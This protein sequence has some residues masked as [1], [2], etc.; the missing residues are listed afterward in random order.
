MTKRAKV[1]VTITGASV[2]CL[3]IGALLSDREP[4][5]KGFTIGQWLKRPYHPEADEALHFLGTNNLLLLVHRLDYERERD[6]F[7]RMLDRLP[8]KI[9]DSRRIDLLASRRES[10]AFDATRLLVR[11]GP[12]A[13]PAIP[14]LARIVTNRGASVPTERAMGVLVTIGDEGAV[15][16][17][18][19]ATQPNAQVRCRA[20]DFLRSYF[21]AN[22]NSTVA[23]YALTNA[24]VDP[25]PQVAEIARN[26]FAYLRRQ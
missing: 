25:D 21:W 26:A 10:L 12:A 19:L 18:S 16:I 15:T 5:Y 11:L 2:L 14:E 3:L 7:C 17:A 20:L 4:T 24:L 6:F 9:R 13:A 8:H 1:A 22:T 23:Y